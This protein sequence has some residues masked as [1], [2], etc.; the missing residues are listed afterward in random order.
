MSR[1]PTA[2]ITAGGTAEPIDDVRVLANVSTGRFGAALARA[3]VDLGADVTVLASERLAQHADWLP[4]PIRVVPFRS[5]ADLDAQLHQALR[6]PP[7]LL[8]MAAAV[9]DYRP[10]PTRGKI[11]SDA[12]ALQLHLER[13]PKILSTLRER[14][15]AQ[16]RL[17]GFKLL[18]GV[19]AT[20]LHEVARAQLQANRLDLCVA[21]DLAELGGATHPVWLVS[22]HTAERVE[23]PRDRVARTLAQRLLPIPPATLPY[24][25]V[26]GP[27][28]GRVQRWFELPRALSDA[29]APSHTPSRWLSTHAAPHRVVAMS[30]SAGGL[31]V[32]LAPGDVA[33]WSALLATLPRDA[34]PIVI[35]GDL[36]G[37]WT[38]GDVAQLSLLPQA[39]ASLD[40]VL[41]LPAVR[42][43]T[44]LTTNNPAPLRD[45][46]FT[47]DANGALTPPWCHPQARHAASLAL[48]HGPTGRVLLGRRTCG[49]AAGTWAFPGGHRLDGESAED[50]AIRELAEET[51]IALS[52][53]EVAPL[54]CR[55]VVPG[56]APPFL[57]TCVLGAVFE[58]PTATPTAELEACWLSFA[59]ARRRPLAPGVAWVLRELEATSARRYPTP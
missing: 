24:A 11:R 40:A 31:R 20:R 32:G 1:R 51:G 14:C 15:G 18:S 27:T 43:T 13:V 21:N 50:A 57:L 6:S 42:A 2:L 33:A 44:C 45:R 56:G 35:D 41:A 47:P 8:L 48:L 37:G 46:G 30:S 52:V 49:A 59:E 29:P 10:T 16:T 25:E 26:S 28:F 38:P 23:G 19:H 34:L 54:G 17:V 7:D 5:A 55:E 39:H 12:D 22:A 36:V 3:L 9:A 4:H 58:A 53:P